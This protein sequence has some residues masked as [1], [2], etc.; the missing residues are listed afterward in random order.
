[1]PMKYDTV[2]SE[3]AS[4]LS[5]G[6]RQRVAIARCLVHSPK[7]IVFDEAT[8]ALD[9]INEQRIEKYLSNLACTRIIIAHRLSTVMD[10]DQ[11]VVM[12]RGQVAACGTH[13]QLLESSDYYQLLIE[14]YIDRSGMKGGENNEQRLEKSLR[15]SS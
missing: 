13:A 4:N 2:L 14:A 12:E 7:I 6:Q 3:A 8:N 11:I 15:Q 5:G 9:S 1:M 10:A